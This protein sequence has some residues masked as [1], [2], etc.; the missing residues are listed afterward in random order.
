LLPHCESLVSIKDLDMD[1]P[2]GHSLV[3]EALN[4]LA[5]TLNEL[6]STPVA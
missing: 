2:S 3:T 6:R 5:V 4:E 1:A